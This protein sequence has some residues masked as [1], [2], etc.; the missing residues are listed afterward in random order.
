[1]GFL[2]VKKSQ[3]VTFFTSNHALGA[4]SMHL[5]ALVQSIHA[6]GAFGMRG[7]LICSWKLRL[8]EARLFKSARR[9]S[10]NSVLK[11]L[12]FFIRLG[13]FFN[14][15]CLGSWEHNYSICNVSWGLFNLQ[16]SSS[17]GPHKSSDVLLCR[18]A[19]FVREFL[20]EH[21][22]MAMFRE[23][24]DYRLKYRKH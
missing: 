23:N 16:Y 1:M 14:V 18:F 15:R 12:F 8:G 4:F 13:V 11:C 2:G 21:P 20:Q 24:S 17:Q 5:G 6:L 9:F 22:K 7:A 10:V 3:K 19:R